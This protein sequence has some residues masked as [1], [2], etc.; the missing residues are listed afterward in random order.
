VGDLKKKEANVNEIKEKMQGAV[1]FVLVNTQGTN[2]EQD[3][4]IRNKMRKEKIFYKVYKNTTIKFAIDGTQFESLNTYL[5]DSTT[6]AISYSTEDPIKL[7]RIINEEKLDTAKPKAGIIEGKLYNAES[8]DN[9]AKITSR[10]ELL[11]EIYQ[12]LRQPLIMFS[13]VIM[14]ISENKKENN[15]DDM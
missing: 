4:S 15:S 13:R 8:F 1:S 3:R 6:L 9:I 12:L 14:S 5:K 2:V 7:I 10:Q 11:S